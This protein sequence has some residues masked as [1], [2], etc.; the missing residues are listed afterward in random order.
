MKKLLL[1]AA[2][3]FVL[4]CVLLVFYNG[5]NKNDEYSD[6]T[7]DTLF[8]LVNSGSILSIYKENS[9]DVM[10]VVYQEGYK[11]GITIMMDANGLPLTY[12]DWK[13]MQ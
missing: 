3:L 9:T 2:I 7:T 11:G 8:T 1:V 5:V 13:N 12:S 4:M 10:Y 6:I